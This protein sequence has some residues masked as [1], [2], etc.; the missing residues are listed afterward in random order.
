MK[1][2]VSLE[3]IESKIRNHEK[4]RRAGSSTL[5]AFI[6][7]ATQVKD[8]YPQDIQ[9]RPTG[10]YLPFSLAIGGKDANFTDAV[11]VRK[12]EIDLALKTCEPERSFADPQGKTWPLPEKRKEWRFSGYKRVI[13]LHAQAD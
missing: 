10:S 6:E 1:S 13:R 8:A 2:S 12:G 4:L 7:L 3:S 11:A 9:I 5:D